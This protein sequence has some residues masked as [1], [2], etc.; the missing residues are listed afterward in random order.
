[1]V[2]DYL[3]KVHARAQHHLRISEVGLGG[4]ELVVVTA[5]DDDDE[6]EEGE[7]VEKKK[8]KK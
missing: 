2:E 1:V 5:E 6:E 4:L 8:G 3:D 7:G